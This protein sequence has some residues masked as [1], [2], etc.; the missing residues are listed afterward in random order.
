MAPFLR[1]RAD[2]QW[3]EHLYVLSIDDRLVKVGRSWNP[4]Q[5]LHQI[6][7]GCPVLD[8]DMGAVF[9]GRGAIEAIV[10]KV[11]RVKFA[12][13]GGEWYAASPADVFGVVALVAETLDLV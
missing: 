4:T 10:H 13:V 12:R 11:C 3:G 1:R 9:P 7:L 5:R 6:R 2:A 8:I